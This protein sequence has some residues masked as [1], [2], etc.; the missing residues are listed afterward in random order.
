MTINKNFFIDT[1]GCQL[2]ISDSNIIIQIMTQAGFNF[3]KNYNYADVIIINTCAFRDDLISNIKS[4]IQIYKFL[5]HANPNLIIV[6][7]GCMAGILKDKFLEIEPS[8]DIVISPQNYKLLPEAIHKKA[9][10]EKRKVIT[11]SNRDES[12]NEFNNKLYVA[13]NAISYIPIMRGFD[14]DCSKC[15]LPKIKGDIHFKKF[16]TILNLVKQANEKSIKKVVFIGHEL[17][18]YND[19]GKKFSELL[20]SAAAINKNMW[21]DYQIIGIDN[22]N[23]DILNAINNNENIVKHIHLPI[24]TVS[25]KLLKILN[26]THTKNSL[27]KTIN[28]IRSNINNVSITA[29]FMVGIPCETIEDINE[30]DDFIKEMQ[31]TNS[32]F[33]K[34]SDVLLNIFSKEYCNEILQQEKN[35]R[36]KHLRNTQKKNTLKAN[37]SDINKNYKVLI[38]G[39]LA[40]S[41]QQFYGKNIY[42]KQVVFPIEHQKIGNIVNVLV[43]KYTSENLIG[44]TSSLDRKID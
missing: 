10:S 15:L 41:Y 12:Y 27:K 13:T 6:A 34:F 24:F 11:N 22:I 23:I 29:D 28:F 25:N 7:S 43:T 17:G 4:K 30:T 8:I 36:L 32:N 39:I 21:I 20:Q 44:Y 19:S 18:K 14:S 16:D 33:Y 35:K 31:F 3:E 1:F 40:R 37:E 42:N 2:N 5:K 38:E 9:N 26:L